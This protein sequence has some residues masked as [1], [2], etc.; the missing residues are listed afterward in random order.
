MNIVLNHNDFNIE[1]IN[2]L[3]KRNNTV[4]EVHLPN[5]LILMKI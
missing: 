2:L 5:L 4:I 1:N 3:K